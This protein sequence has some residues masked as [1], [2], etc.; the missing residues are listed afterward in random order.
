MGLAHREGGGQ[1]LLQGVGFQVVEHEE[2]LILDAREGLVLA[3]S[4]LALSDLDG[5]VADVALPGFAEGLAESLE[6][7]GVEPGMGQQGLGVL[8]EVGVA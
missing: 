3:A 7:L 6:L 1:D 5:V 4:T 8:S 2:E